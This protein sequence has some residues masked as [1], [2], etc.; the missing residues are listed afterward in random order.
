MA[1]NRAAS[2]VKEL[3]KI[4]EAAMS[5]TRA[6][7]RISKALEPTRSFKKAIKTFKVQELV[8]SFEMEARNSKATKNSLKLP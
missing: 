4:G 6:A 7:I 2:M 3:A 5:I 8:K 1:A